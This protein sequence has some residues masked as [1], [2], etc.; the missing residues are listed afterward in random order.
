MR[1]GASE[2]YYTDF[3]DLTSLIRNNWEEFEDLFS[4]VNWVVTRF[5]ELEKSRNI[6]A[7]NNVLEQHEITRIT[8]VFSLGCVRLS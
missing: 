2:I 1:C 6:V 4:D 3:G 7:N 5:E 8:E